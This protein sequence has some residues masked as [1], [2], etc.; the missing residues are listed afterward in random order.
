MAEG[1][2]QLQNWAMYHLGWLF[3]YGEGVPQDNQ[4]AIYWY[5]L[6]SLQNYADAKQRMNSIMAAEENQSKPMRNSEPNPVETEKMDL[7][8]KLLK[9][10]LGKKLITPEEWESKHQEILNDAKP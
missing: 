2:T 3:Q 4:Q 1:Q 8:L 6:A 7:R 5:S 9:R 10:L